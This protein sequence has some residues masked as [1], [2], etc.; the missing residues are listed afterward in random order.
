MKWRFNKQ[1]MQGRSSAEEGSSSAEPMLGKRSS[2]AARTAVDGLN[3]DE[4]EESDAQEGDA[5][6]DDADGGS[7]LKPICMDES[8]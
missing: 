4:S 1:P 6:E 5:Q 2:R 3:S 8:D 7:P